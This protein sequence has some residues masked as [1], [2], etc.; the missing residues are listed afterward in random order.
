MYYIKKTFTVSSSHKL[1]LDY[2]S[3]CSNLHGHNWKITVFCKSETLNSNGM[4]VDFTHV[5]KLV[6]GKFDHKY[7]NDVFSGN[8]TAENL[9]KFI[10]DEVPKCFK[11]IVE[12]TEGNEA[13][14][15]RD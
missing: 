3:R 9:A 5:K 8:P 15:E 12:E 6:H 10:C 4:V 11:V 2:E 13:I 14:Y 1:K 7:I